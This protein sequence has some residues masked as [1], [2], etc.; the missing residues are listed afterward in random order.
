MQDLRA[1]VVPQ[2]CK[3]P[4]VKHERGAFLPVNALGFEMR[5][6][7]LGGD[8]LVQDIGSKASEERMAVFFRRGQKGDV[9]GRP[10]AHGVLVGDEGRSQAST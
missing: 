8:V 2:S 10:Q 9:G 1:Q 7:A 4:L 5:E 3:T 6:Q